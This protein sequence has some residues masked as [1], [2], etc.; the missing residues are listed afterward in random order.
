MSRSNPAKRDLFTTARSGYTITRDVGETK[1]E[2]ESRKRRMLKG[3]KRNPSDEYTAAAEASEDFHGTNPHE[4][5]E[6]STQIFE[7]E[8]L[9]DCG[10]LVKLEIIGVHGG[11]IDLKKFGGA[12]LAMAPKGYPYQLYIVG[13]DQEVDLEQFEIER[14]HEHEVL[15][16][17]KFVTYYT[18]KHHLGRDG[19]DANYRH[20]FSDNRGPMVRRGAKAAN[21]PTV[22][23]DVNNKLL[24]FAGGEYDI[25][26]EGID[27]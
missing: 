24:S 13:G 22:L 11:L 14:P 8:H 25:L 10:E 26:P 23:Y 1:K 12:R 19:G 20:K 16:T 21:R 2:W 6:V 3:T 5:I 15:G 27:N 17:L 7:H 4:L 9:A 18:I